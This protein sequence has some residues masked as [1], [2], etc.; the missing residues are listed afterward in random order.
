MAKMKK[1]KKGRNLR[2]GERQR[3]DGR[4]EYRYTDV[5]GAPRSVY[6]WT[7]VDTDRAPAGKSATKSLRRMEDEIRRDI[8]D[9]IDSHT[10]RQMTL[11]TLFDKYMSSKKELK[12]STRAGYKTMY[13]SCIRDS[14]GQMKLENIKYSDIKNFYNN[15]ITDRGFQINSLE[16]VQSI[17]HPIFRLAVRDGLIRQNPT[18]G[19]MK[20]IKRSRNWVQ[21][22]RHSL[23]NAQQDALLDY[24]SNN[25]V[26]RHWL[27]ILTFFLGT[28]CRV[29]EV[30]GLRWEDCDFEQDLITIDHSL[31]YRQGEDGGDCRLRFSTTKT[32]AGKRII[33]MFQD[34]R[35]LLLEEHLRQKKNGF[36]HHVVDGVSGFVFQ[37][38]YGGCLL[39]SS[40]NRAIDRIVRD[41]NKEE[42]CR[43]EEEG[44][45]AVL[46]PHF[47]A[48][49]LRHTFCTRLCEQETN[50]KIIQEIMGHTD[51]TTTMNVYNESN[52]EKKVE[53]F[54]QLEGKF[55]IS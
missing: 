11:N 55:R 6:S 53:C 46:L 31:I 15:L 47:S 13:K 28:G 20:E 5:N 52:T 4:Y 43:A 27:P 34:V 19:V 2:S 17:L 30:I 42:T 40:I 37:N 41:Y 14:I 7:L 38:R 12:H 33:P 21:P 16:N 49:H 35:R 54:A 23:T 24:V 26:Y 51:I 29:G 32:N 25:G 39:P 44:R 1:D 22:K 18:D 36:N 48:H 45:E 3:A 50:L 10:A 8:D 9:R